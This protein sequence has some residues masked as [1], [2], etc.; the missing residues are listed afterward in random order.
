MQVLSILAASRRWPSQLGHGIEF[1]D[2][3][4]RHAQLFKGLA[5]HY[6]TYGGALP[7]DSTKV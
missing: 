1:K 2:F 7:E 3:E 5:Q 4:L 6:G